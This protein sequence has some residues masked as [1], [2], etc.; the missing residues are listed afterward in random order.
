[1]DLAQ[2]ESIRERLIVYSPFNNYAPSQ[3]DLKG[4]QVEG[5]Q[6]NIQKVADLPQTDYYEPYEH[7]QPVK[8]KKQRARINRKEGR[9]EATDE[10]VGVQ[11]VQYNAQPKASPERSKDWDPLGPAAEWTE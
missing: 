11:F 10:D 9:R 6:K 8:K 2:S 1:M 7:A 5:Y 4:L 3:K